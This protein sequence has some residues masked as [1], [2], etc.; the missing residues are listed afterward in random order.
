[1]LGSR[2]LGDPLAGG[3][4]RW[5]YVSNRFLTDVENLAFGLHL[6]EYHTGLRAY[7][8]RLLETIPYEL[9]SNDFVFDQELIA[10]VVA[11]GMGRRI[12]EIAV[13]TRYF[14]EASSV[15]FKRSVVYGL[16]TLRV[17]A[18]YLLHRQ[19]RPA[20]AQADGPA[21]PPAGAE[22]AASRRD[23]SAARHPGRDRDRDLG[24]RAR[25]RPARRRPGPDR[26]HPARAPIPAWIA[27]S[28]GLQAIDLL[29]RG[30]PLAA[31]PRA[32]SSA[33]ATRR[34]SATC[35]S[36]TSPT[37]SC[38]RGSASSSA[39]TTSATARA[40]AGP[41]A[42]GTVVVE[43]VVDTVVVVAIAAVALLVLTSA[44]SS[45]SAVLVGL[46]SPALLVVALALGIVAHRLPGA[47]RVV[48]FAER[49]PRVARA[50]PPSCSEGL[51]VA[52]RPR[53]LVEALV[54]SVAGLGRAILRRSPRPASRS[55]WSS[56]SARR[57]CSSSGVALA[58]AIP[59]GPGYSGRSSSPRRRSARP[60]A[61]RATRRSRSASSSTPRS[62]S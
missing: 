1:M 54:L 38:R 40:S 14:E 50:R 39:A 46:A 2:F 25:L 61:C 15:G 20:V 13:P 29:L 31:P 42:L 57:R 32:R 35:S 51:A 3:M 19:R 10:Q 12:G 47:D 28:V 36:A 24:R 45:P 49:R 17:V 58:T 37:T 48:A 18:R 26:R 56:R 52:G 27:V 11:A 5:K 34:C 55:A 22:A 60:S 16:S 30:A 8:R 9:N 44:A 41:P 33:S 23:A 21:P 4:P 62:S 53:T 6:S 7:S 59:S 43:R